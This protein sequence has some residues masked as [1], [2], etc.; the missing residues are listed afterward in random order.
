[1]ELPYYAIA[2]FPKVKRTIQ[3]EQKVEKVKT[4][5][6]ESHTISTLISWDTYPRVL[7]ISRADGIYNFPEN[8][9]A[10]FL[11]GAQRHVIRGH[12]CKLLDL[13]W[14][15]TGMHMRVRVSRADTPC[16]LRCIYTS[17]RSLSLSSPFSHAVDFWISRHCRGDNSCLS[18][19]PGNA[20]KDA[21]TT[22][23][24]Y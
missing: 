15:G 4:R 24:A 2:I 11:R 23:S 17:F 18:R 20:I 5:Q 8:H 1:M 21:G 19:N 6:T 13:L 10:G 9:G 12:S 22:I 7:V 14:R 3:K 16:W